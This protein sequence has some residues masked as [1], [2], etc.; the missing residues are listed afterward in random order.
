MPHF[1]FI[2]FFTPIINSTS[3]ETI[4][5]FEVI[6]QTPT[7]D[8][9]IERVKATDKFSFNGVRLTLINVTKEIEGKYACL[10]G[11]SIGY[12]VEHLYLKVISKAGRHLV[13]LV[14]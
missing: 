11:N 5:R 7:D 1:Q 9:V 4:Q 3:N 12:N 8:Q 13:W 6:K 2:R 14:R 10:V